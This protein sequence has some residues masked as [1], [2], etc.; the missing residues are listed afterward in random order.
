MRVE[1]DPDKNHANFKKHGLW[2]ENVE[3]LDWNTVV[4]RHDTRRDYGEVRLIAFVMKDGRLYVVCY[5]ARLTG[6][7]RVISFRK[8][9]KREIR[10]YEQERKTTTDQ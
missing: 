8:A 7:L 4:F 5:T 1:F 2:F 3:D 9:N 6:V 10:F